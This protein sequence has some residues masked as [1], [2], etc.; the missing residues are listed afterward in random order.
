MNIIVF[1]HILW[2]WENF[3]QNIITF[4]I[5]K[6][7]DAQSDCFKFISHRYINTQSYSFIT[8]RIGD[9]RWRATFLLNHHAI[10]K[11]KRDKQIIS[12]TKKKFKALSPFFSNY[13]NY[14]N[15]LYPFC[16]VD[17]W[18]SIHFFEVSIEELESKTKKWH[19][20]WLRFFSLI[21]F[22]DKHHGWN[23]FEFLSQKIFLKPQPR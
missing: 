10:Y 12:D 3:I 11:K 19:L 13:I 5:S 17:G 4:W 7:R 2:K 16:G 20:L 9:N 18:P 23:I 14:K 21:I 6:Y 15:G 8:S 22:F 1:A